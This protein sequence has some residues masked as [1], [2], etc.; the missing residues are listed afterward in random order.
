MIWLNNVTKY[1]MNNEEKHYV[2]KNESLLIP[3]SVNVGI[4]GR[5]GAGKS[6]LL[7]LLGGMDFPNSGSIVSNKKFSWPI[8][9]QGGFQASMTG[10]QVVR[11]VCRIYGQSSDAIIKHIDEVEEFAELGEYFDL[12]I[13]SYSSGMRSR[14]AFGLSLTFDFDYLLIDEA[15]SVGDAYFQAKAKE[16]LKVKLEKCN[17]LLVSHNMHTLNELCDVGIVVFDSKMYYFDNISD[18]IDEYKRINT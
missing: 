13:K 5:N 8:G 18:A 15:L 2:L 4:L 16:A 9:L 14:L 10:R 7:R 6:T 3:S 1:Y 11:F 17:Y 12:P